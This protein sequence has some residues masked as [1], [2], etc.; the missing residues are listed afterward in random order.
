MFCTKNVSNNEM[1]IAAVLGVPNA[2]WESKKRPDE[3]QAI[4]TFK[5]TVAT[6]ADVCTA[7]MENLYTAVYT[8]QV[9]RGQR[10]LKG[11]GGKT[12]RPGGRRP[13]E[14]EWQV[15]HLQ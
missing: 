1:S 11:R 6:W 10:R 3:D 5:K 2:F 9:R 12:L 15:V 4:E 14:S 13:T 7:A 8:F